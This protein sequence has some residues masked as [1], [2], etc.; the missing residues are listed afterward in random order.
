MTRIPVT[1][2]EIRQLSPTVKAF[3]VDLKGQEFTFL[4]GQWVDCYAEIDGRMEVGGYSMTSSP[5]VKDCFELAVKLVGS[6]AVTSYLHQ[7]AKVGDTLYVEGGQGDFYYTR[8]MGGPLVLMA[9]GIGITPIMSIARYVN[10][11]APGVRTTLLYSASIPSELLFRDELEGMARRSPG[12]SCH[13]TVTRTPNESWAGRV[14]R[15]DADM[16]REAQ[17]DL[18][19]LFYICGPPTMIQCMVEL[20]KSLGVPDSRIHYEQWW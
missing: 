2:A 3:T 11:A 15:I 17:A 18:S 7:Q 14:G 19:A 20:V 13:F 6:N 16:L 12:F 4:P 5:L 9:G 10:E 1:I 8:D